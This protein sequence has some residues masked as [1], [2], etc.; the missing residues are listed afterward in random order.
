MKF[1]WNHAESFQLAFYN[2]VKTLIDRDYKLFPRINSAAD[3]FDK[4]T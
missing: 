4:H 1:N 2:F 3:D